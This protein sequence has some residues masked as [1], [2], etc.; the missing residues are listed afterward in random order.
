[1]AISLI[2][3]RAQVGVQAPPVQVETHLGPGLPAFNIVGLPEAA[4]RESRDRVRSAIVNSGF[5]FP[6]QR[7]TVNLAPADLP[8]V[9]GRFD[10]PI[11]LGIL[12]ATKQLP[13]HSESMEYLGELALSGA[14]RPIQGV[15]PAALACGK[16]D[17]ALMIPYDNGTEASLC[18]QTE[19]FAAQSLLEV[20]AHWSKQTLLQPL[21]HQT[22]RHHTAAGACLS[23][24]R[25]QLQARRALEIAASGGHSLLM[26]GPPGSGKSMLASRLPSLL[27][28]LQ[29]EE[30]LEV[31][32]V[33]SLHRSRAADDFYQRPFRAP[34]HTA[35]AVALVGGG[36][37][38]RPGEISLAH[39]GI[40]FLDELP[41][42][43]RKVLEVLREPLETGEV[44]IARAT[45]QATFPARFQLIAA[46][47][48]CPCGYLGNPEK[49]CGYHCDKAKR[50]QGKISGPFLDRIDLQLEVQA[51]RA[52]E[53]MAYDVGESSEL[54]RRRVKATQQRQLKRQGKLNHLLDID[55]LKP[56]IDQHRDWL[57]H[58]LDSLSISARALHRTAR[59]ARTLADMADLEAV[60]QVQLQEALG[61]RISH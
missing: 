57:M 9:G 6:Q 27:P 8:K 59:V 56:I 36:S 43:D 1:M 22:P 35:S 16:A 50:Y 58:V 31:A 38:P 60:T 20:C 24:V 17:Y 5:Q 42:F 11:A 61:F 55:E 30:A 53:L 46:M 28:P 14:L 18:R 34:H 3:T 47:N 10:L 41:E 15:L 48:P 12:A 37:N 52:D 19:I 32:S 29:E 45:R 44:S 4:V 40:L 7:I 21:Q 23:Q 33:H 25:G 49:S 13:A 26:S 54:V 39:R 51:V 2:R